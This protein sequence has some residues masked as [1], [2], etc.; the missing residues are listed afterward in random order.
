[1]IDTVY[2]GIYGRSKIDS[3]LNCCFS[4]QLCTEID[5]SLYYGQ[6]DN[7]DFYQATDQLGIFDQNSLITE[8]PYKECLSEESP[9]WKALLQITE[10]IERNIP[11]NGLVD[12][13]YRFVALKSNTADGYLLHL[14]PI[15][16][17]AKMINKTLGWK[18]KDLLTGQ[19]GTAHVPL[20][21]DFDKA[22]S[23]NLDYCVVTTFRITL[24]DSQKL[25]SATEYVWNVTGHEYLFKLHEANRQIAKKII[26]EFAAHSDGFLV[27]SDKYQV[28]LPDTEELF[29]VVKDDLRTIN[30][31]AKY[32]GGADDF[33][34]SKVKAANE[35]LN[36]V[37]R[38]LIND[39][40]KTITVNKECI[41]TFTA[42]IHNL[43]L[44]RLISGDVEIPFKNHH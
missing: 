1:M 38:V 18:I 33:D 28:S 44:E 14:I 36:S 13:S 30:R 6:K 43:L 12:E 21:V 20:T 26:G 16:R 34:I 22:S 3:V 31:L 32:R 41:G 15:Y 19:M 7:E 5:K 2:L 39:E 23:L 27:S 29:A 11:S 24:D 8:D 42:L 40:K 25:L 9:E 10:G 37:D 17:G 35:K 4:Q